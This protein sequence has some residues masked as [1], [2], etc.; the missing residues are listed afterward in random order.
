VRKRIGIRNK[1]AHTDASEELDSEE[2]EL[3]VG[4]L[5]DQLH[6]ALHRRVLNKVLF[7]RLQVVLRVRTRESKIQTILVN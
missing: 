6:E 4:D 1:A 5:A 2:E 3:V 7:Q